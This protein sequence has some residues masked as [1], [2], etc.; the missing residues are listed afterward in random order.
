M[1]YD[2]YDKF[3]RK[4]YIKELKQLWLHTRLFRELEDDPTSKDVFVTMGLLS[5]MSYDV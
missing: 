5:Y 1:D 2:E 4:K 3:K